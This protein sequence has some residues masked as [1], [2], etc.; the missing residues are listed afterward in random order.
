MA[1]IFIKGYGRKKERMPPNKAAK[2]VQNKEDN[3]DD[4]IPGGMVEKLVNPD[5][6]L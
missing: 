3:D 2:V 6:N 5:R 1:E 4:G